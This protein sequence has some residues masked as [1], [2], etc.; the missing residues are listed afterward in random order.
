VCVVLLTL[1]GSSSQLSA[2]FF[3]PRRSCCI[4]FFF[5]CCFF[6]TLYSLLRT[7]PRLRCERKSDFAFFPLSLLESF[8][9]NSTPSIFLPPVVDCSGYRSAFLTSMFPP[10]FDLHS[11][12]VA[13]PGSF[14][15]SMA[16]TPVSLSLSSTR[17]MLVFFFLGAGIVFHSFLPLYPDG[18]IGWDVAC[19]FFTLPFIR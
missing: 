2:F 6:P 14:R 11:S 15:E 3:A 7:R 10:F 16:G 4:F 18:N 19:D 13:V 9:W 12:M 8:A 17:L 1:S 5:L